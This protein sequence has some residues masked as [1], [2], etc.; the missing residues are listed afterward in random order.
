[1]R[2]K[3]GLAAMLALTATPVM[4]NPDQAI[5]D[6]LTQLNFDVLGFAPLISEIDQ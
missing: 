2:L 4:A 6:A 5:R 3:L 1:M